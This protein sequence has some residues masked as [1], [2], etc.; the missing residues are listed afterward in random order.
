MQ[1]EIQNRPTNQFQQAR[2]RPRLLDMSPQMSDLWLV[3]SKERK[4]QF[5]KHHDLVTKLQKTKARS[6]FLQQCIDKKVIPKTFKVKTVPDTKFSDNGR[7]KWLNNVKTMELNNL[8]I[9]LKELSLQVKNQSDLVTQSK[10]R[11]YQAFT[12]EEQ[13]ILDNEFMKRQVKAKNCEKDKFNIK[14]QNL[15][16]NNSNLKDPQVEP[17]ITNGSNVDNTS[18]KKRQRR[19]LKRSRYRR[20]LKKLSKKPMQNLCMNYSSLEL[21]EDQRS[22]L[23]RHLSFVPVPKKVNKT[24]LLY[25]VKRFSR[26]MRWKEFFGEA[27]TQQS[28]AIFSVKKH[29]L[30]KNAPSKALEKFLYGVETDILSIDN[31]H[32]PSNLSAG[33]RIALDELIQKQ[34]KGEIVIQR[35]DKGG[36]VGIMDRVDYVSKVKSEHLESKVI[37]SDGSEMPVYRELDPVMLIVHYDKIKDAASQAVE[38]GFISQGLASQMVPEAPK[39]A[40][41]YGMPKAHKGIPEGEKIPPLRLVISGCG[42]TTENASQFIDHFCKS[43]PSKL[44][45][46]IE[47][48]P[49]ILRILE[50][51][52]KNSTQSENS[53]PV[54]IDVVGLYPNI[55]QDEGMSAFEQFISDQNYR[56]QSEMPTNFLM[57]LLKFVLSFN[58]FYFDGT[59]Y[60]QQWG[61]AI[62]TRVAPTY[63][64]IFMAYI[65]S[66]I[67]SLWKGRSPDMWRRFL[68]D[69]FS[70]WSGTVE[71]LL[72]FLDFMNSFHS[73]I[74]FTAEFRTKTHQYKV[75][76]KDN[77]NIVTT[78]LLQNL[79]PRSVDFLDT[80]IWINDEGKFCTD[81]FVKDSDRITYL[82]PQSCHPSFICKNIPY[83]LGYRLKRIC[84]S[85]NT[86]KNRLQEL[87]ANLQS[88]GYPL[89][90]IQNAFVKLKNISRCDAL[91]KVVKK[92]DSSNVIFVVTYDPRVP[93][94]SNVIQKHYNVAINNPDFHANFQNIPRIAFRR[95]QNLG[96]LLIRSKLY[97]LNDNQHNLRIQKGFFCCNKRHFGC[98]MCRLSENSKTHYSAFSSKKYEIKS[99]IRCSDSYVIYSIQCKR[100]PKVQY[101]GQ[102][103]QPI[104]KRFYNHYNDILSKNLQKAVSKHFNSHGH[105]SSD[106]FMT[107][108]EKLRKKDKTLLDIREKF[109]IVE[110]NTAK[111]G[112]NK[113]L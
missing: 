22:L 109:W 83:S 70:I 79:K 111:T 56:E 96:D 61:T 35:C 60:L 80:T 78:S 3:L 84:S 72:L 26:S 57:K 66:K 94:P 77:K 89:K 19:F 46:H 44:E 92:K 45:S 36:A 88:R 108:F 98:T 86:F 51:L 12:S 11:F 65:E 30:P 17:P 9:A 13:D 103:T 62:G 48:T 68:D 97:D 81:L 34:K 41:A 37:K 69:I 40:T 112:L 1:P 53:F 91:K 74:K 67:L 14:F 63:A 47:D 64:T 4:K 39:P 102:T 32:Y 15:S 7:A 95:S 73:T 113:I 110:K 85:S 5:H 82:M 54:T 23:N 101:V 55:P 16:S 6:S 28:D 29:N 107:P 52:N 59:L 33:E 25:D 50:D 27:D 104:S 42:S 2:G 99:L 10:L 58:S 21:S 87:S 100:C 76:W 43:I 31:R 8:K 24:Q 75:K 38:D 106:F 20:K 93:S 49:H 18:G 105:S 90:I 71:E